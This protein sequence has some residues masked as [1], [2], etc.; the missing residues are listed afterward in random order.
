VLIH[1]QVEFILEEQ[2]RPIIQMHC[3]TTH[4]RMNGCPEKYYPEA[5]GLVLF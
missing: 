1:D 3:K 5:V 2:R 4:Q